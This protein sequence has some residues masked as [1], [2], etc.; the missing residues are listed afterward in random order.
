MRMWG[1]ILFNIP[2]GVLGLVSTRTWNYEDGGK[3][4]R[5]NLLEKLKWWGGVVR[6]LAADVPYI[7]SM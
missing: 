2:K 4:G 3:R 1:Q 6:V 7:L 5:V